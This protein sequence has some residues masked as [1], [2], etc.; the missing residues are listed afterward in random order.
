[1]ANRSDSICNEASL[2]LKSLGANV[3]TDCSSRKSRSPVQDRKNPVHKTRNRGYNR[4]IS[5]MSRQQCEDMMSMA[6][7]TRESSSANPHNNFWPA[8]KSGAILNSV[9]EEA[10]SLLLTGIVCDALANALGRYVL[11]ILVSKGL[12]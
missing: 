11:D 5:Q 1:M 2:L 12:L 8:Q 7:G 3:S 4:F 10:F 6:M 9:V